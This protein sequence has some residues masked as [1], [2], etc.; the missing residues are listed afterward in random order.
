MTSDIVILVHG[1]WSDEHAW[2]A[3]RTLFSQDSQL[4]TITTL[5]YNYFSPKLKFSPVTAVP[6]LN[7]CA[8]GLASFVRLK[9]AREDRVVIV[10]HSQGG[11][12]VQRFLQRQLAIADPTLL[13]RIRHISLFACPNTGSDI[14]TWFRKVAIRGNPQERDL[15]PFVNAVA[16]AHASVLE[17][18]VY[19]AAP[20]GLNIRIPLRAYVGSSDRIVPPASARGAF[21]DAEVLPGNHSTIIRPPTSTDTR[22]LALRADLLKAFSVDSVSPSCM[23]FESPA[24]D[25]DIGL[26]LGRPTPPIT[27]PAS[28]H[29]TYLEG[30]RR[31]ITSERAFWQDQL[32]RPFVREE[33][34][35]REVGKR[36]AKAP[37]TD[38]EL[39][40]GEQLRQD[41]GSGSITTIIGRAGVGKTWL[42]FHLTEALAT[43]STTDTTPIPYFIEATALR[44]NLTGS[45]VYDAVAD[46][47]RSWAITSLDL[48]GQR[49]LS[50]FLRRKLVDGL[51]IV[52]IDAIDDLPSSIQRLILGAL[53]PL[54]GE[55]HN[56]V[57]LSAREALHWFKPDRRE[58]SSATFE[59]LP[60]E[61][62]EIK[63]FV[64][65]ACSENESGVL[66]A[67]LDS[68][69]SLSSLVADPLLCHSLCVLSGDA[70]QHDRAYRR[71]EI[72][73]AL[74]NTLLRREWHSPESPEPDEITRRRQVLTEAAS[75]PV[76]AGWTITPGQPVPLTGKAWPSEEALIRF[77][78]ELGSLSEICSVQGN[79]G[80]EEAVVFRHRSMQE[81]L[82]A[83]EFVQ[84]FG[85]NEQQEAIADL[86]FVDSWTSTLGFVLELSPVRDDLIRYCLDLP[87]DACHRTVLM[88]GQ[89]LA[90]GRFPTVH[91]EDIIDRLTT[92]AFSVSTTVQEN[93]LRI[94]R[95]LGN[96]ESLTRLAWTQNAPVSTRIS[97]LSMIADIDP[98]R[99]VRLVLANRTLASISTVVPQF[100]RDLDKRAQVVAVAR[101]L[102]SERLSHHPGTLAEVANCGDRSLSAM[103]GPAV[104]EIVDPL[105][106]LTF[107]RTLNQTGFEIAH[108]THFMSDAYPPIVQLMSGFKLRKFVEHRDLESVIA[109]NI[110]DDNGFIRVLSAALT[111]V[112]D[113]RQG[114]SAM[115]ALAE[116]EL[117]LDE[118]VV[119]IALL[120]S[121]MH[122]SSC[123]GQLKDIFDSIGA[124]FLGMQITPALMFG[125]PRL[126]FA[127]KDMLAI[128][129][130]FAPSMVASDLVKRDL[131]DVPDLAYEDLWEHSEIGSLV[132]LAISWFRVRSGPR[133]WLTRASDCLQ[134]VAYDL[135]DRARLVESIVAREDGG[136][137]LFDELLMHVGDQD[138]IA[139]AMHAPTA[140]PAATALIRRSFLASV[141]AGDSPD[142]VV[143]LCRALRSTDYAL[144]AS[145]MVWSLIEN[146][147]IPAKSLDGAIHALAWDS[148]WVEESRQSAVRFLARF[149]GSGV[150]RNAL[151]SSL[152]IDAESDAGRLYVFLRDSRHL[153]EGES[154]DRWWGAVVDHFD[155]FIPHPAL[156]GETSSAVL[157]FFPATDFDL[158][159][160]I[161]RRASGKV[162][163]LTRRDLA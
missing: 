59:L 1:F 18:I 40:I 51:A 149:S 20:H 153:V 65:N 25:A 33:W 5:P 154:F 57:I 72:H 41:V 39:L 118:L 9:T 122:D 121:E 145:R 32:L 82:L 34:R 136:L 53:E 79:V 69:A 29:V 86:R 131:P 38:I 21:P 113:R 139:F 84:K 64:R 77:R 100:S 44:A 71:S 23:E 81:Y 52:F 3:L 127:S 119:C 27:D 4:A 106:A 147:G 158:G 78:S 112:F 92:C 155:E 148:P 30:V 125:D 140:S 15:R 90:V 87:F 160:A 28:L 101:S 37:V 61:V 129:L 144:E 76:R 60:M 103:L 161:R 102:G 141:D 162:V 66:L 67:R 6:D 14:A 85:L 80:S 48:D 151:F 94:L 156:R 73:D 35:L 107:L 132:R 54:A 8:D 157:P 130:R 42:Q 2:D 10:T 47:A 89:S 19:G 56:R 163:G 93:A 45:N 83:C 109:R 26:G 91:L 50:Q 152:L 98:Y 13:R 126:G 22:Y 114:R 12:I 24:P 123:A 97:A 36:E 31:R 134:L 88:I 115:R 62:E 120:L 74:L 16:E 133:R 142:R 137:E 108:P 105:E 117:D 68:D 70:A 46:A 99:A 138:G 49:K 124:F 7:I 55:G 128:G 143:A 116:S 146:G 17:R 159:L 63:T 111:C 110:A 75:A 58:S 95:D 43:T 150:A 135:T 104:R 96:I 11:L